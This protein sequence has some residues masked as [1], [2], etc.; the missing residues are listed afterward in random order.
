MTK[1]SLFIL[2]E[3]DRGVFQ[4]L[5]VKVPTA[6]VVDFCNFEKEQMQQIA[7]DVLIA[8][9]VVEGKLLILCIDIFSRPRGWIS[10]PN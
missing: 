7:A 3:L 5:Q 6:E 10:R 1:V 2:F 4:R 9:D 8:T